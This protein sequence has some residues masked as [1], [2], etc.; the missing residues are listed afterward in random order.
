MPKRAQPDAPPKP[1]QVWY[2]RAQAVRGRVLWESNMSVEYMA[3][4]LERAFKE[5]EQHGYESLRDVV[6]Q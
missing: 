3:R 5:G 6:A 1:A 4:E 2:E